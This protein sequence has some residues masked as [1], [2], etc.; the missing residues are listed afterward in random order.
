MQGPVRSLL[1]FRT[2]S[3]LR[4]LVSVGIEQDD[5]G[6]LA[7]K[8]E[9][10]VGPFYQNLVLLRYPRSEKPDSRESPKTGLFAVISS[11]FVSQMALL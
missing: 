2:N 5:F 8:G 3:G 10:A 6:T 7:M 9:S 1:L 4:D 11:P